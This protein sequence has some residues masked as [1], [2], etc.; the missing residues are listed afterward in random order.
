[1]SISSNNI[2]IQSVSNKIKELLQL[3]NQSVTAHNALFSNKADI[4]HTHSEYVNP[5]IVDNLTTNDATKTLSAKQGKVLK[6]KIDEVYEKIMGD[7][8]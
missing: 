6:E 1:M 7:N 5:D 3:H 8:Q 4:N 2:N